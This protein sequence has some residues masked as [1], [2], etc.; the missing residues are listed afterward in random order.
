MITDSPPAGSVSDVVTPQITIY[1]QISD[2]VNLKQTLEKLEKKRINLLSKVGYVE[3][4][5]SLLLMVL[6]VG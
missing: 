5:Q 6:L 4:N 3:H 2:G 1:L